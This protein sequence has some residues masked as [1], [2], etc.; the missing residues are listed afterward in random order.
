MLLDN[1]QLK[2]EPKKIQTGFRSPLL[3]KAHGWLIHTSYY[4]RDF[5]TSWE[6]KCPNNKL[7]GNLETVEIYGQ[8]PIESLF[9][10]H[11]KL[12]L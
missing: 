12:S 6:E 7:A 4:E 8:P 5:W 11:L 3:F 9:G 1:L 10:L 2:K